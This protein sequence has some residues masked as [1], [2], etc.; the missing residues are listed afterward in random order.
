LIL[1][2]LQ[3]DEAYRVSNGYPAMNKVRIF[4]KFSDILITPKW[5]FH[6]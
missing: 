2:Q 4:R 1:E 6:I 3:V 5:L